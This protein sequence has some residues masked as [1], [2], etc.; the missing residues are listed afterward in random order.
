M[1][2]L[3]QHCVAPCLL[4][5]DPQLLPAEGSAQCQGVRRF[6]GFDLGVRLC[7]LRVFGCLS[8]L[9]GPLSRGPS[10]GAL[11]V[12]PLE[13]RPLEVPAGCAPTA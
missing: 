10:C 11:E 6:V 8:W 3:K 5:D 7:S 2:N 1:H 13:V 9:I 12:R 4:M